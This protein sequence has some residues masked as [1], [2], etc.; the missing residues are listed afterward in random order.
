[1]AKK[2]FTLTARVSTDNRKAIKPILEEMVPKESITVTE[3]GFLVEAT[4][5]GESAREMNKELLSALRRAERKTRVRSEWT[6]GGTTER[7]F[8]Y[9]PKGS[10]KA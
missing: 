1:M 2:K 3:E 10:S 4:M 8:D 6:S 9:V 5:Y 7:F